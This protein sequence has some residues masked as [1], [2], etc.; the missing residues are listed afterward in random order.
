[1]MVLHSG[2]ILNPKYFDFGLPAYL[3]GLEEAR[4]DVSKV[5]LG[6]FGVSALP[7]QNSKF[8]QLPFSPLAG[9]TYTLTNTSTDLENSKEQFVQMTLQNLSTNQPVVNRYFVAN[10]KEPQKWIFSVPERNSDTFGIYLYAGTKGHT[11]GAKASID[12]IQIQE[13]IAE[14]KRL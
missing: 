14:G 6:D 8:I 3:K 12:G 10:S 9:K 4:R 5:A 13:G 2:E 11:Q 7:K 1:I